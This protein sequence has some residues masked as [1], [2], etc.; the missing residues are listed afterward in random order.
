M[1]G[2]GQ[3]IEMPLV[4]VVTPSWN[5]GHYLEETI[6]SVLSQDYPRIEY[7]VMDGGSTDE[8]PRILERHGAELR[9]Y[10]SPDN[11]A[12]DAINKGLR[13]A[14]GDLCAWLSAD[15]TYLPNAITTVVAAFRDH[16]AAGVI[17]GEGLWTDASGSVLGRYPTSPRAVEEFDREC[18]IC[19][20]AAF[21]R[22]ASVERIGFLNSRL[23]SAFDYDLWV[24][25]S[26][27]TRFRH[28][29]RDLATSRMHGANKTL[30][31]RGATLRE[32]IRVQKTH[33]GYV[34]FRSV[35]AYCS[36]LI[37]RNRQFPVPTQPSL[38][39]FALSFPVGLWIDRSAPL[40]YA[41]EWGGALRKGL[42]RLRR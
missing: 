14:S 32:A 11:G 15:D 25:L 27:C 3:P 33:F 22:R 35:Y 7:I 36:W 17:Y 16:P 1:P 4:S 23:S 30:G 41:G 26:S 9:Y 40:R 37:A 10:V 12:A 28:I 34:P 5:M 24:R 6:Q 18:A 8:T 39:S 21:F 20:P 29:H 38:P 13:L 19:Q 2:A 31:Q 42:S